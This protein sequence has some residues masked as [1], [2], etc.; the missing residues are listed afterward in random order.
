MK[1]PIWFAAFVFAANTLGMG[2]AII[3]GAA[4]GVHPDGIAMFSMLVIFAA[5]FAASIFMV[6]AGVRAWKNTP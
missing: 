3:S 1:P 4:R 2:S 5:N 6:L